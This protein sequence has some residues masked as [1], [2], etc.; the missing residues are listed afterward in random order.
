MMFGSLR[1]RIDDVKT[2]KV[3]L[4]GAEEIAR[5]EGRAHPA[6]EHLLLAALNLPDG[7][8]RAALARIG[9][10]A[11]ALT[12]ALHEQ[13]VAALESIGVVVDHD[14][15][16]AGLPEPGPAAG[17]YH[18][19]ASAQDL[20][21]RAGADARASGGGLVGAHVVKAAATLE[22]GTLAGVLQH[23]GIDRDALRDA[24]TAEIDA[25]SK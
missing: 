12:A 11:Q 25:T 16:A 8:A 23:L 24:A 20:F 9:V 3:L 19:D 2:I 13:H 7:T 18:S 22:R 21:Q 4:S 10:S 17:V 5:R 14:A 1:R 15:I 6:A